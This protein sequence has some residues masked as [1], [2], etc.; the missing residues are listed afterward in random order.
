MNY[1]RDTV[2]WLYRRMLKSQ[3]R[4]EQSFLQRLYGRLTGKWHMNLVIDPILLNGH[5]RKIK[6]ILAHNN[7]IGGKKSELANEKDIRANI[8]TRV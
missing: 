3:Y 2:P 7:K 1:Y 6:I 8:G 4:L 5:V